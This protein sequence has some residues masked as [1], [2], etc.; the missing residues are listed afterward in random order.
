MYGETFYGLH[1]AQTQQAWYA[2]KVQGVTQSQAAVVRRKTKTKKER[3]KK[4]KK[5]KKKKTES[6]ENDCDFVELFSLTALEFG[7]TLVCKI[8]YLPCRTT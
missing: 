5:K 4:K 6:V 1:T 3:K 7:Q 8:H 2:R